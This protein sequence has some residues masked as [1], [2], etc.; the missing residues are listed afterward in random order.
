LDKFKN[1]TKVFY[2]MPKLK[3]IK[4]GLIRDHFPE[5]TDLSVRVYYASLGDDNLMDF[6]AFGDSKGGYFV[7][8]DKIFKRAPIDVV[9]G[10]MAH[11]FAHGLHVL[12]HNWVESWIDH[13]KYSFS[14]RHYAA[15]E[16]TVDMTVLERGLAPQLIAFV[17]WT[18]NRGHSPDLYVSLDEM[19]RFL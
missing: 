6:G 8:V 7:G 5:Y 17:N 15:Q 12:H 16:I 18:T 11:E 3:H 19:E 4:N 10:G 14:K 2:F 1:Q 13:L 9:V